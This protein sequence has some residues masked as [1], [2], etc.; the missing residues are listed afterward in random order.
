MAIDLGKAFVNLTVEIGELSKGFKLATD[1]AKRAAKD[2]SDEAVRA[3]KAIE[4]SFTK[5][6]D[7]AE[8]DAKRMGDA[9]SR[10]YEKGKKGVEAAGKAREKY[11]LDALDSLLKGT[12]KEVAAK[13]KGEK[14]K[15]DAADKARKKEAA[16]NEKALNKKLADERAAD[17]RLHA[18]S[19]KFYADKAARRNK[20]IN[21]EQSG[22]LRKI[23]GNK[24]ALEVQLKDHVKASEKAKA[25]L[26]RLSGEVATGLG[27]LGAGLL[28]GVTLPLVA[29][30]KG[31]V[32]SAIK[33]DSLKRGL[34]SVTGSSEETERQLVR[35]KEAAKL[36][37]L[38]FAEAIQGS[39]RLQAAGFSANQAE[40]ALKAFGNALATVGKGKRE[41]DL[42]Q[43]ALSQMATKAK[44]FGQDMRQL[45]EHLPQLQKA[46]KDA[47]G[48]SDTEAIANL[49][50]TG[51][52]V[53]AKLVTEFEK[54]PK[55]APGVQAALENIGDS[56]FRA[57]AEIGGTFLPDIAK[58]LEFA[59]DKLEVFTSAWKSLPPIVH[60]GALGLGV[61]AASL[62]VAAIGLSGIISLYRNLKPVIDRVKEAFAALS[63]VMMANP[64][65]RIATIAAIALGVAI[66]GLVA[67][68]QK[69]RMA[70]K[71]SAEAEAKA[72]AERI[73]NHKAT[74]A[75]IGEYEKLKNNTNKTAIES[76]RMQSILNEISMLHPQLIDGYTKQGNAI[77]LVGDYTK[78]A[79]NETENL[80]KVEHELEAQ[81]RI[82]AGDRLREIDAEI[83]AREG[84]NVSG[85]VI[86]LQGRGSSR[87]FD[88]TP[89]EIA[90]NQLAI[91]KLQG[92]K[93]AI[94]KTLP[95]GNPNFGKT[96]SILGPATPLSPAAKLR[97]DIADVDAK[98][99][100]YNDEFENP[101]TS[102]SAKNYAV[103]EIA[104]LG[105]KK[106]SLESQLPDALEKTAKE[107]ADKAERRREAEADSQIRK[108][109]KA[110][111]KL[112]ARRK[113]AEEKLRKARK[114]G[115][116]SESTALEEFR[117]EMEDAQKD[118]QK[119]LD[120][121]AE[122]KAKKVETNWKKYDDAVANKLKKEDELKKKH[123]DMRDRN[124]QTEVETLELNGEEV[125]AAKLKADDDFVKATER[126]ED[127]VL[128][129]LKRTLA[130]RA[131][132]AKELDRMKTANAN[133]QEAVQ[134]G[135]DDDKKTDEDIAKNEREVG[136]QRLE[137]YLD[138]EKKL[139][140][141]AEKTAEL[142]IA[143]LYAL[144]EAETN[145]I[146]GI[147]KKR[148]ADIAEAKRKADVRLGEGLGKDVVKDAQN[149]DEAKARQDANEKIN[150][151]NQDR[152]KRM[153]E[154]ARDS[155]GGLFATSLASEFANA[156]SSGLEKIF[157]NNMFGRALARAVDKFMSRIMEGGLDKLFASIAGSVQSAFNPAQIGEANGGGTGGGAILGST[158]QRPGGGMNWNGIGYGIGISSALAGLTAKKKKFAPLLG[159]GLGALFGGGIGSG[160]GGLVG[161]FLGFADGG[162]VPGPVGKAQL[163][164]V[165][166]GEEVIP[167]GGGRGGSGVTINIS[168]VT[169]GS[170][171][172]VD[173]MIDRIAW[174]TNRR[175]AVN[176]G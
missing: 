73:K 153:Q 82:A 163:A 27:A 98:I 64:I 43:L 45:S 97:Q 128:A 34:T 79:A 155:F 14:R 176:P 159:A 16:E 11:A 67:I 31:S 137:D 9:F 48:T 86:R 175:L 4:K 117:S 23:N 5:I 156:F 103:G 25:A 131:A 44:G 1:I 145:V 26:Q 112:P 61:F 22:L 123:L 36:P 105:T 129:Q 154:K 160:I 108:L 30:A 99:K 119:R 20:D 102:I 7:A 12:E 35:L 157:G 24:A 6:A 136:K 144:A 138:R 143:T 15:T 71:E 41:L 80:K 2:M 95:S 17:A 51:T 152:F 70:S 42:V 76:E 32:D 135:I 124:H 84:Q 161:S 127:V 170:D 88:I 53:V 29:L 21:D 13:E 59:T 87:L 100:K 120:K 50:F 121:I 38:G 68:T 151:L 149:A 74:I 18:D 33:L 56:A 173:R 118:E 113:A 58:G 94:K 40:R 167:N 92:E 172:D 134:K 69:L 81:R 158:Q 109:E 148:D 55:V 75:L 147:M 52:Q 83:A 60:T 85:K 126:G 116:V 139:Q 57:L 122:L 115:L 28:I 10:A 171:Y 104:R 90:S 54:L 165:H 91:R 125:E 162:T 37:G 101:K 19:Q 72:T 63:V 93:G 107:A 111:N 166:G 110:D 49:G 39:T 46:L 142:K 47:F 3:Q 146:L 150:K 130:Y 174:R 96:P 132:D 62:G 66:T 164:V 168:G 169:V 89:Q 133:R 106:E 140:T 77:K 114:E 8:R 65:I 78:I 141:A